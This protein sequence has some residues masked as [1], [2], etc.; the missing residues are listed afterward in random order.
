MH[1]LFCAIVA[2]GATASETAPC[3]LQD[4]AFLFLDSFLLDKV[5]GAQLHVNPPINTELVLIADK[6]WE[7]GGITGYGNVL[8]DNRTGEYRLYYVPVC[9]DVEPGFCYAMATSQDG[10]HW[11]K[12]NL[13][14]VE[15][16]G[17]TENN[18]VLWAQRE[19]TVIIDPNAPPEARYGLVSSHPELK[20]RLFTSPDGIHFTMTET[21]V[22][23]LHSD[24]QV[25]TFWDE[26]RQRYF[27]YPRN[28][29]EGLRAC[30]VLTTQTLAEPWPEDIALAIAP[31]ERDPSG[32]DLYTNACQKY[33]LA[34]NVY[35]GFPTPYYHY[36]PSER[37]YLNKPTLDMGGK[38]NDGTIE[39]QLATSRD[40]LHWTR[41]RTPYVAVDQYDGLEIK[42]AQV[43]PGMIRE[44]DRIYQYFAGYAFTHGDTQVRHRGG[45]RALG[46][47]FRTEQRVDGFVSLDFDYE[48]GSVVTEPFTF[49]GSRL[50]LKCEHL[51]C[52]R[53]PRGPARCRRETHARLH[54]RG[55]PHHQR[56]LHRQNRSM[57]RWK[58]GRIRASGPSG[59]PALRL[60]RRQTLRL[61]I[62]DTRPSR[63]LC[64]RTQGG[65]SGAQLRTPHGTPPGTPWTP[66]SVPNSSLTTS[67]SKKPKVWSRPHTPQSVFKT[68]PSWVMNP[69]S[70]NPTS[71]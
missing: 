55:F 11:Q 17:S 23:S 24:S 1:L 10:L 7:T 54:P 30:G 25:S 53:G 66:S 56:Q 38:T 43:L 42:I 46:G 12:P 37:A 29:H 2:L 68:S 51:G 59:P 60:P 20:T 6:P 35:L 62:H 41:Y 13:G 65:G 61:S 34:P 58:L 47:I 63:A 15:W 39:T 67:S 70:R 32:M 28:V 26:D 18:I 5:E 36:N 49:A 8:H 9:W 16:K 31:D 3:A 57:G 45:G 19:G 48:G 33:P 50:V 52:G 4:H 64:R 14:S 44:G 69:A 71:P 27:H 40:G 21:P 22:S